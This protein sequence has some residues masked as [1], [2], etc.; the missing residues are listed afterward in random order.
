MFSHLNQR[1]ITLSWNVSTVNMSKWGVSTNTTGYTKIERPFFKSGL[2]CAT[3]GPEITI[4]KLGMLPVSPEA[5]KTPQE[6]LQSQLTWAHGAH[7]H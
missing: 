2:G 6:D 1:H 4:Y 7:R 3:V 5:S